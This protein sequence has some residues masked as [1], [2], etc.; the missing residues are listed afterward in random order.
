[1][2]VSLKENELENFIKSIDQ[3]NDGHIDFD[4]FIHAFSDMFSRKLTRDEL[5]QVFSLMDKDNSS[6]LNIDEVEEVYQKLRIPY[7][8]EGLVRMFEQIDK[9]NSGFISFD[10]FFDYIEII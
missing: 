6:S 1:M 9:D 3:N 10:E 5:K 4:E 2:N 8:K 7:S